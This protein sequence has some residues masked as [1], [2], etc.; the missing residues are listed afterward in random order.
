MNIINYILNIVTSIIY[1]VNISKLQCLL[2]NDSRRLKYRYIA[3]PFI[4]AGI[5]RSYFLGISSSVQF[6]IL[7]IIYFSL[8]FAIAVI[9]SRRSKLT[10]IY[11]TLTYLII[12]S[13]VESLACII[14]RVLLISFDRELT[15]KSASIIFGAAAYIMMKKN[16]PTSSRFRE[17]AQL[18]SKR[19]Y[20][21]VLVTLLVIGN[22]CANMSVVSEN[23]SFFNRVNY[24]LI[25]ILVLLFLMIVVSFVFKSISNRYYENISK[26]MERTVKQQLEHYEKVSELYKEMREFRHDYKNHMI[27][28]QALIEQKDIEQADEYIKKIT[29]QEIVENKNYFTGN[30]TADAILSDKNRAAEKAGN[31]I[32]FSGSISDKINPVDLCTVLSNALDNAVKACGKIN[33][34]EA[35]CIN[36]ECA[37]IQN[38]QVIKISNPNCADLTA[39]EKRNNDHHGI[40]LYNIRRT[41]EMLD[42]QMVIPQRTPEFI[43]EVEFPIKG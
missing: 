15:L 23:I 19:M 30:H 12:D 37:V 41:A 42:G 32:R 18:L 3:V 2:Q 16:E 43:L 34:N 10:A 4:I 22:L 14:L 28:L 13:I 33:S 17:S 8:P 1:L 36:I 26:V 20:I 40:G 25:V 38:V 24:F 27:C 29:K 9:N 6:F 39:A 7:F 31:Y 5:G 11:S 21:L 35:L